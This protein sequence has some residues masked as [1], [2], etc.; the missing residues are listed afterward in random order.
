MKKAVGMKA[1][2]LTQA[3]AGLQLMLSLAVALYIGGFGEYIF[4]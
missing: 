3:F 4:Y 2:P 1:S